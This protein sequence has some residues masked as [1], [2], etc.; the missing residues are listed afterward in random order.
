MYDLNLSG[1]PSEICILN[2]SKSVLV[3]GDVLLNALYVGL[4][5][6]YVLR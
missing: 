5:M 2:L 1:W 4:N 3:M 6:V